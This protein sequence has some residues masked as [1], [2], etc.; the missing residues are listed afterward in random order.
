MLSLHRLQ[1][2]R[3][4]RLPGLP[5]PGKGPRT[6][7]P[8]SRLI[9]GTTPAVPRTPPAHRGTTPA[10][11]RTP[12][13]LTGEGGREAVGGDGGEAGEVGQGDDGPLGQDPF[14]QAV[15]A[16]RLAGLQLLGA[17]DPGGGAPDGRGRERV[18]DHASADGLVAAAV[19]Q[20]QGLEHV[21]DHRPLQVQPHQSVA[22]GADL[23]GVERLEAGRGLG[24]AGID[25]VG[26]APA[27]RGG[28][29]GQAAQPAVDRAGRRPLA[30]QHHHV[31]PVN[32]AGGDPGQVDRHPAGRRRHLQGAAVALEAAD[33]DPAPGRQQLGLAVGP[34]RPAG[35]GPGD[36]RPAAP[37]GEHPVHRDPRPAPVRRLR[38]PVEGGVQGGRQRVHA[39]AG[40][41]GGG[42]HGRP[43]QGRAAEPVAHLGGHP[44]P[45]G[46]VDQVHLGQRN[47]PGGD[48]EQVEDGQV[49]GRLRPPALAGVDH[50]Q[51]AVD[52]AHPGEHVV[53]EPLVAGDVDEADLAAG[54]QGGPGE[55]E[56][57]RQAPRLLLG[58]PVRVGPGQ[59]LDQRRLAVVDM[60]GGADDVRHQGPEGAGGPAGPAGGP[61]AAAS[62]RATTSSCSGGTVRRS[63]TT[64]PRSALA[65]TG[66]SP[67]RSRASTAAA[68]AG[69]G[70][71]S[72]STLS[73]PS[74]GRLPPPATLVPVRREAAGPTEAARAAARGCELGHGQQQGPPHGQL[75][76]AAGQVGGQGRLQGGQGQLVG[77][78]RPGQRVPGQPPDQLGPAH[79]QAGLRAAEE[80]VAGEQHQVGA[81]GQAAGDR[82]LVP[83]LA[84]QQPRPDVVEQR[85]AV[86]VGQRGQLVEGRAGGEPLDPVV[87]RVH[88]QHQPRVRAEPGGVVAQVGAVGGADL[89]QHHPGRLHDLGEPELAPDLDQLPPGDQHLPAPGEPAEGEEQRPGGVVHGQRGL[90]PGGLAQQRL[91]RGPAPAPGPGRQVVL[92][93][94]VP[95]GLGHR[96]PGRRRQRRPPQVRVEHHPG[97]VH[98]RPGPCRPATVQLPGHPRR[99]LVN[100][101][102]RPTTG[103]RPAADLQR[104]PSRPEHRGP[105]EHRRPL[106]QFRMPEQHVHVRQQPTRIARHAPIVDDPGSRRSLQ[107]RVGVTPPRP[108]AAPHPPGA[109]RSPTPSAW[110]PDPPLPGPLGEPGT[111]HPRPRRA[112]VGSAAGRVGWARN[113]AGL[114]N[115]AEEDPGGCRPP[116]R[117][118]GGAAARRAGWA[119][120]V[121]AAAA[122]GDGVRGRAVGVPRGAGRPGRPRPGGG[123]DLGWAAPAA[124]A[125]RLGLPVDEARG[126]VVAA[127]RETLEEAGLLLATPAAGAEELAAAR[128]ELLA[129]VAGFA[130][131]LA[132]LGVRLDTGRLRYWAWWVTPEEEPRRYDTRFFVAGLPDDAAVTVHLAEAEGER[133]LPPAEAAADQSLPMLPPTR[134]TL[135]DLAAFGSV[136]A[137]LAAGAGRPVERIQP[138]LDGA[139][140][141][142]PW[143]ER[144]PLPAPLLEAGRAARPAAPEGGEAGAGRPGGSGEAALEA[145][146]P[147]GTA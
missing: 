4:G 67:A 29:A 54:R 41:G 105:P 14:Q 104:P 96:R 117:C 22:A 40:R 53:D 118:D 26:A 42:H 30:G 28:G 59:G 147:G 125:E 16:G 9:R 106:D 70:S 78:D 98:H 63:S 107:C 48:A 27:Q 145:G 35:E 44:V 85:Q 51:G 47:H 127:C 45:G 124:W 99:Q 12:P 123:R 75:V 137:A 128:G 93:G 112:G 115:Q 133:W 81:G 108:G 61:R 65:T 3:P 102:H 73:M 143:R 82:R 1:H 33:P 84:G 121:P 25:Q 94:G 111:P 120:G 13:T 21:Q 92:H 90:G 129:G 68:P 139:E 57:D 23:G 52:P 91:G 138:V 135:R 71:T 36:H 31:A 134:Y 86:L 97:G 38:Q 132:R 24:R 114:R 64:R 2:R 89:A 74:P 130:E 58:Q 141:V 113:H 146:G 87:G 79:D 18:E 8:T 5:G 55:P 76:A 144:Y 140:L 122:G 66:G 37:H 46:P 77:P 19:P 83:E 50:E 131:L 136:E 69:A 103:D 126:Q 10:V 34:Q 15:P 60:A 17:A 109:G 32:L 95:G 43:G 20:D 6:D 11:P 39:H 142:M 119:G 72:T 100:P 101:R 56:V 62:A 7:H 88:G 116:T 49:L 80:L 110:H